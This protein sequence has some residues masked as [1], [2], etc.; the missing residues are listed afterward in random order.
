MSLA[1]AKDL[2]FKY[3]KEP[4][5]R[6]EFADLSS[7]EPYGVLEDVMLEIGERHVPTDFQ[8]MV[9]E[10]SKRNQL[11]LGTPFLATAGAI[12]NY[13]RNQLTL[14][15]VRQDVFFPSINFKQAPSAVKLPPEI[16]TFMPEE[17][18]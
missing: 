17:G 9:W 7:M 4:K 5:V 6:V 12:I 8:I 13:M 1:L 16:S 3:F 18:A 2:G 14:G 15:H 11:I 10:A